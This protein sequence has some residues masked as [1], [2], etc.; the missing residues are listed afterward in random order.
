M[1]RREKPIRDNWPSGRLILSESL[2]EFDGPAIFTA[3]V[4]LHT[5]L[6]LKKDE[7]EDSDFLISCIVS[8]PEIQALRGG[9]L[10][11]RGVF[12]SKSGWLLEID[13]EMAVIG[14]QELSA[15]ELSPLLPPAG[16]GL[17]ANF[18]AVPDSI[19]QAEA[20]MAFKFYADSMSPRSMPLSVFKELVDN[21]A[22][23]VRSTLTP[24]TL[25]GT[26]RD[27]RFFDL[28]IGEPQF[29]SL[30]IPIKAAT[31]DEQGLRG[32]WRTHDLSPQELRRES[33]IRR[34]SLW[35]LILRTSEI[36]S[37]GELSDNDIVANHAL[38]RDLVSILPTEYND[39]E[40]LEVTYRQADRTEIVVINKQA[41]E[42]LRIAH[43]AV[44]DRITTVEGVIIEVNGESGTFII[45][46]IG[47][48]LTTCKPS[49]EIFDRMDQNN[50][51]ER[52]QRLA[53]TGRYWRRT[54][55]GYMLVITYPRVL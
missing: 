12:S 7:Q 36:A 52:G 50:L 20:L 31:I 23:F 11:V 53:V 51:L 5:H 27:H 18:A 44:E 42:R 43:E 38:L 19:D 3:D 30:L 41:G 49:T 10:S 9:R 17:S 25:L 22:N 15:Q 40:K 6:F 14:F 54:R 47:E 4:G 37:K 8:D 33:D 45:K 35:D 28:E 34:R 1:W 26:G 46:D 2:Y 29:A 55:R 39:L 13:P 24:S 48:H 21:V 16:V 32:F